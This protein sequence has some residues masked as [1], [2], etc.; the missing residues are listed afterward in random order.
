MWR[1]P[2]GRVAVWM[3]QKSLWEGWEEHGSWLP[4]W[5]TE[6]GYG[7]WVKE[8]PHCEQDDSAPAYSSPSSTPA[9]QLDHLAFFLSGGLSTT[10]MMPQ[11]QEDGTMALVPAS[12]FSRM[13]LG[14]ENSKHNTEEAEETFSYAE[15]DFPSLK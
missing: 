7:P 6:D 10:M 11:V 5:E 2:C 12:E 1:F 3:Q 14:S 8:A 4:V 13:Q 9:C 15:S